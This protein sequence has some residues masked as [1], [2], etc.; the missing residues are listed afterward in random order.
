MVEHVT[1]IAPNIPCVSVP[2]GTKATAAVPPFQVTRAVTGHTS[3]VF[4]GEAV[5]PWSPF[6]LLFYYV[7]RIFP[8]CHYEVAWVTR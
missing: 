1:A 4:R 5:G 6:G 2:T 3:D 7:Y 8:L